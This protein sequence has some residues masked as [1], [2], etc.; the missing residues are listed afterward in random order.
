MTII[1][2]FNA[3]FTNLKYTFKLNKNSCCISI[4]S[5]LNKFDDRN[6]FIANQF[7]A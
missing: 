4:I 2:Y 7:F 1:N 3:T 6:N 5:I